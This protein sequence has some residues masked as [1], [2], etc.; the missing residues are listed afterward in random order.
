MIETA[1]EFEPFRGADAQGRMVARVE[2]HRRKYGIAVAIQQLRLDRRVRLR[3]RTG[4]NRL[5]RYR[6]PIGKPHTS[7]S[8]NAISHRGWRIV[9]RRAEV[10]LPVD[11]RQAHRP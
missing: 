6:S 5:D 8:R 11:E 2:E 7:A 9:A 3:R 10:A 4:H 1:L